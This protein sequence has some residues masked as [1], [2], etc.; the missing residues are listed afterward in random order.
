LRN[1]ILFAQPFNLILLSAKLS[2]QRV[3][4]LLLSCKFLVFRFLCGGH[5][6]N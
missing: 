3:V 6:K 1:A 2:T 4:N 5:Q